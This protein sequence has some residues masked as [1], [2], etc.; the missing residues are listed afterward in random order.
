MFFARPTG[1]SENSFL[2]SPVFPNQQRT[3]DWNCTLQEMSQSHVYGAH[4]LIPHVWL[5]EI[6]A[7]CEWMH[8]V[9]IRVSL[10]QGD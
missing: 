5:V 4:W 9:R 8:Q 1:T 10:V 7:H 6:A 2:S 3:S